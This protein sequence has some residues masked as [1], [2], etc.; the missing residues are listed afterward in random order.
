MFF[1]KVF[2]IETGFK[3]DAFNPIHKYTHTNMNF[4]LFCFQKQVIKNFTIRQPTLCAAELKKSYSFATFKNYF[5]TSALLTQ[6]EILQLEKRGFPGW[7]IW[8]Q[9]SVNWLRNTLYWTVFLQ[10]ILEN[11]LSSRNSS[12]YLKIIIHIFSFIKFH[13]AIDIRLFI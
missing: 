10:S 13:Y 4:T 11:L 1:N 9:R 6:C 5:S 3:V 7:C 8:Y 2:N 12:L